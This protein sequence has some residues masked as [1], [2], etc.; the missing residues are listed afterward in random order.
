MTTFSTLQSIEKAWAER[1]TSVAGESRQSFERRE[2]LLRSAI[3]DGIPTTR[4]EEWKYT[5]LRPLVDQSFRLWS[6]LPSPA[7]DSAVD[8][9][10]KSK[11]IPDATYLVFIDGILNARLSSLEELTSLGFR[12]L[13]E[14]ESTNDASWW[15][16]WQASPGMNGLFAG[17]NVGFVRDGALLELKKNQIVS[18]PLHILHVVTGHADAAASATSAIIFPRL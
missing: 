4:H 16:F 1:S 18:R 17:I 15:D 6:S 12:T 8:A 9:L 11:L 13:A 5:S 14:A 7:L 10:V 2:R 3:K